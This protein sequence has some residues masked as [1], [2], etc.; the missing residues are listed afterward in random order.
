MVNVQP[1]TNKAATG[2][3][4]LGLHRPRCRSMLTLELHAWAMFFLY[5]G[6]SA[7]SSNSATA[8]CLESPCLLDLAKR[9]CMLGGSAHRYESTSVAAMLGI[10]KQQVLKVCI[11]CSQTGQ[12]M[13][14]EMYKILIW[15]GPYAVCVHVGLMCEAV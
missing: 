2:C 8:V 5:L 6:P 15:L 3:S 12:S 14:H 9:L 13:Y 4:S 11:M 1:L 10:L 7:D